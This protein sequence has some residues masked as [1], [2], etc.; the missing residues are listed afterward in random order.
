[1]LGA[2][3]VGAI[4][5]SDFVLERQCCQHFDSPVVREH[6]RE[7]ECD[8]RIRIDIDDRAV[9]RFRIDVVRADANDPVAFLGDL[10]ERSH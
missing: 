9:A 8:L 6:V 3:D 1:V 5:Q 10:R 2:A 4:G 7:V